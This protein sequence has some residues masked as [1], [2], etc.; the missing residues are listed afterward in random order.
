MACWAAQ[1]LHSMPHRAV[2]PA[3][4]TRCRPTLRVLPSAHSRIYVCLPALPPPQEPKACSIVL[5]GASKDVLNEVERNLHDAMGVARNVCIGGCAWL[6][7]A[8]ASQGRSGS[9][10]LMDAASL[11]LSAAPVSAVCACFAQPQ[12]QG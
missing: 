6:P 3:L 12:R 8:P 10:A 1:P 5:R 2:P 9:R 4:L 11:L 7:R